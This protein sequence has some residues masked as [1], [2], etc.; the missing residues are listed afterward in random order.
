MHKSYDC[1]T[2]C[3]HHAAWQATCLAYEGHQLIVVFSPHSFY[4]AAG[5]FKRKQ[6]SNAAE[7]TSD[8]SSRRAT[9]LPLHSQ[10][11]LPCQQPAAAAGASEAEQAATQT[12]PDQHRDLL[13]T[14]VKQH[15]ASHGSDEGQSLEE[16]LSWLRTA[17]PASQAA[18]AA[19]SSTNLPGNA[20]P[21]S[22]TRYQTA[23]HLGLRSNSGSGSDLA[24]P[25]GSSPISSQKRV[26]GKAMP[27]AS[28]DPDQASMPH[29]RTAQGEQA[30]ADRREDGRDICE[31]LGQ[32]A[33]TE[34]EDV[35]GEDGGLEDSRWSDDWTQLPPPGSSDGTLGGAGPDACSWDSSSLSN[36]ARETRRPRSAAACFRQQAA[37]G[38]PRVQLQNFRDIGCSLFSAR[39][40]HQHLHIE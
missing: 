6:A 16:A 12:Q 14:P 37:E 13:N 28:A 7:Q 22:E 19:F 3:W 4:V 17:E 26:L 2:L 23:E 24:S 11:Q 36:S 9:A 18:A 5:M 35:A 1:L 33:P 29:G 21:A 25:S 15:P 40:S 20:P 10:S 39:T 34:P 31:S 32:D 30:D 27:T 8:L 38:I